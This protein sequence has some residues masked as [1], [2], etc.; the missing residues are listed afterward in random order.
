[1]VRAL[2]THGCRARGLA[3]FL[4]RKVREF[5]SP[6]KAFCVVESFDVPRP[7]VENSFFLRGVLFPRRTAEGDIPAGPFLS[8]ASPRLYMIFY[9]SFPPSLR[10]LVH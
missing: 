6:W 9:S 1:M 3:V 2:F 8:K 5:F 7:S 4:S 10:S